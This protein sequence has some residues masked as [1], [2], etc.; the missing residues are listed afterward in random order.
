MS[1][2]VSSRVLKAMGLFG[3]VRMLQIIF[4][5]VRVKL[6]ALWLGPA[7]VGLFGIFN[8]AVET[9]RTLAQL[10]MSSS[11]VREI[12]ARTEPVERARMITVV[13]RWGWM[14]GLFGAVLMAACAPLLSRWT[15]GS[16]DHTMSYVALSAVIFLLCVNSAGEAVMQ[17]SGSLRP[18]AKASVWGAATGLLISAPMYCFWG[19]ASVIPSIIAYAMATCAFTLWFSRRTTAPGVTKISVSA[20]ETVALGRRFII[21]GIFMTAADFIAQ[22][23]SYVF[24]AWLNSRAGDSEVGLYQAGYTV[25]NRYVGLIFA[26][27]ATEYY[28]RLARVASSGLRLRVFVAHE[29]RVILLLLLPAVT[30][31][32]ALAPLIVN[33]L[34]DSRFAAAVPF[35]TIA[36]AGVVLRGVSY[37]MSYVIL[38]RGDGHTFLWTESLSAVAG[39][40]LN[41]GCYSAWGIA[42]LGVSYTLWYLIYVIIVGWVY[43]FHYGLTL[44]TRVM[45]FAVLTVGVAVAA[46]ALST[47]VNPLCLLPLALIIAALSLRSLRRLVGGRKDF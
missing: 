21:L 30:A 5:V 6:V 15:F 27:I 19:L 40:A 31:L 8:N 44:P 12:A 10:G 24:V 18:L 33:L 35:I 46:I 32:I 42:G 11:S 43:R 28:P 38:A 16:P 29:M 14:L 1:A 22:A 9:V 13:R 25:V 26:A 3:G 36:M 17:G 4:G 7:G 41:I 45:G 39:L 47:V 2:S 23:M 37:C 20:R 34:Y